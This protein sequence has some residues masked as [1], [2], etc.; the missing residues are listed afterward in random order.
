M[1]DEIDTP[2]FLYIGNEIA[3]KGKVVEVIQSLILSWH[4]DKTFGE[5][6]KQSLN[7]IKWTH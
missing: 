4:S 2:E 6:G 3:L 5:G 7:V 1:E